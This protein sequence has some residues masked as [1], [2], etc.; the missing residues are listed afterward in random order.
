M[1]VIIERRDE[2]IGDAVRALGIALLA[3]EFDPDLAEGRRQG[4]VED[5]RGEVMAF[6]VSSIRKWQP[7]CADD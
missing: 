5:R 7:A 1:A 6:P 2:D 4:G 3:G